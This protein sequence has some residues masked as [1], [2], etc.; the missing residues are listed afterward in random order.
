MILKL[1][2]NNFEF[3]QFYK[4]SQ[5]GIDIGNSYIKIGIFRNGGVDI[6]QYEA[7]NRKFP[8]MIAF[9]EK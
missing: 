7:G 5:I 1:K 6:I 3:S 9:T 4:M 8:T 2:F